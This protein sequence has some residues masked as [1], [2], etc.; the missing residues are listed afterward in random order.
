MGQRG[1]TL[2]LSKNNTPLR[3]YQ[4]HTHL[5][6]PQTK[7]NKM[8]TPDEP[9]LCEEAKRYVL[10]PVRHAEAYAWYKRIRAASWEVGEVDLSHDLGDWGRLTADERHFVSHVLAFFAASDGI[11]NENLAERFGREI[12]ALEFKMFYDEQKT[13]ENVHS[14]MYSTLIMTYVRDE[15]TRAH[16]FDAIDTIPCV[17]RKALWAQKWIA[18]PDSFATRLVAFAVVEG[19]FFSGS[20]CAIFWL[21]RRGLMPGLCHSNELISRDE[22]MHQEFACY[23][24]A[25]L[26]RRLDH[27]VVHAIVSEAVEEECAFCTEA[28]PVALIGMNAGDMAQYIRF[29]ADRL[30]T[31]LGAPK[32]YHATNPFDWMELLS[33]EGKTNF[34]E[35]R[36]GEYQKAGAKA[37]GGAH[38]FSVDAEF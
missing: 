25:Q 19:I 18:S 22:G 24:Y 37:T 15:A 13:Q 17:R 28:L 4:K 27:A 7:Q 29:V 5:H 21:K 35:R 9:L 2:L 20:F 1:A 26:A 8:T 11:V 34:F 38:E 14:E 12:Q 31:Q 3:E 6:L 32:L 33:L 10:F 36:V 16:L 30:L 23:V